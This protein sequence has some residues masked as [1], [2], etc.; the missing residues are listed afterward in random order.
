MNSQKMSHQQLIQA[1]GQ[2]TVIQ[3][4]DFVQE[5]E[6]TWGISAT[7]PVIDDTPIWIP[8]EPESFDVVLLSFGAKKIAVIKEL[9]STLG[10][11]L[12]EA[13]SLVESVPTMVMEAGSKEE[14]E[15]MKAR[16][17]ALG[18]ELVLRGRES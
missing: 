11:G 14:A 10:L 17:E 13:K 8:P 1:L 6:E 4:I 9:R 15:A 7:P 2:L 5:L 12:K 18:A 16:F 3:A